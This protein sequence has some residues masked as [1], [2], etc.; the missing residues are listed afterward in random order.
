MKRITEVG[1]TPI[2]M[3]A[4]DTGDGIDKILLDKR[5]AYDRGLVDELCKSYYSFTDKSDI[6]LDRLQKKSTVKVPK[7]MKALGDFDD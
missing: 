7:W 6:R 4:G 5:K 3:I 1:Y 2:V